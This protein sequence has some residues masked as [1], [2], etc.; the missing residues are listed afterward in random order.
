[1]HTKHNEMS[2]H[3]RLTLQMQGQPMSTVKGSGWETLFDQGICWKQGMFQ[4]ML[5]VWDNV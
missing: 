5:T 3:R 4:N 1:M 2:G